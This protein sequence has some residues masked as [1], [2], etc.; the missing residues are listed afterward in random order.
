[1]KVHGDNKP[2][3]FTVEKQPKLPGYVLIRFYENAFP[4]ESDTY[5][6]WEYDEYHLEFPE[7]HDMATYITNH[8][9]ELLQEA[10]GGPSATEQLRADLD[11]IM[12]LG[13]F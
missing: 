11:Y 8:Y 4:V 13:G 9:H 2:T 1:M 7:R 6:G 10:K 5:T 12:L 3:T